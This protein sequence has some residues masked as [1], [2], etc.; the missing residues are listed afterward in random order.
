MSTFDRVKAADSPQQGMLALARAIDALDV[1]L[2]K[3]IDQEPTTDEWGKWEAPD[4]PDASDELRAVL[5]ALETETD[6]EE[7]D[8]LEARRRLLTDDGSNQELGLA[9]G[10]RAVVESDEDGAAVSLPTPSKRQVE[11]RMLFTEKVLKETHP[12]YYE[13]Y[14]ESFLRGGPRILY[15]GDRDFV[16]QLPDEW[17]RVFVEDVEEDSPAEA[18]EIA[19]DIL[20]DMTAG[21]PDLSIERLQRLAAN[22]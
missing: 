11:R 12:E 19:R 14:R 4:E 6:P 5:A 20:K 21:D 8:A 9:E 2:S 18:H 3:L 7:R 13:A 15:Y 22:M 1:K 10:K 17:R 16:M